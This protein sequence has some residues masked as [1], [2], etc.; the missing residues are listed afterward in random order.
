MNVEGKPTR[1]IWFENGQVHV[2]DQTKLPFEYEILKLDQ[3]EALIVAIKD[4]IVRGA[5]VIGAT[6]A[7]AMYFA[8]LEAKAS[9][10]FNEHFNRLAEEIKSARPTAVNLMFSVDWMMAKIDEQ[11]DNQFV[12]QL[13]KTYAEKDV[14]DCFKIGQLG[15]ELITDI[16]KKKG[17]TVNVLTHCNAGWLATGEYGTA[18]APIYLAHEAGI[19][20]HVWVDETRPRNQGANLTAWEL[21]QHGVPFTVIADN[22]GGHLMQH[23]MVD[24][25]IVGSD[26]TT[27]NGDVANKIGTYLK[28]LA[29][30]DNQVPFYVALPT[31]TIDF[32]LQDGVKNIPIEQRDA[33]ELTHLRALDVNQQVSEVQ[34]YPTNVPTANYAFDVTPAK[35][36]TALITEK[37]IVKA[38]YE[39]ISVLK[40]LNL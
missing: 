18:T 36:V 7:Y 20:V 3:T 8:F 31:S 32:D 35:Y 37:A 6:A 2:I 39:E 15:R 30:H 23:Q 25:C 11:S 4:M 27:V 19:P 10:H 9:D 17:T 40:G 33:K 5:P 22:T 26:R 21:Q 34:I 1:A 38:N 24:L 16:Y 14:D 28:A 29:A 12:L 13:A